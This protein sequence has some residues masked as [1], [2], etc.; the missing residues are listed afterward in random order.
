MC[1]IVGS[2]N[3]PLV[4]QI[5]DAEM[6]HRGPDERKLEQ[7][8]NISFYHL[9]LSIIDEEGGKQ[10]MHFE[11]RY[12][13]IFNG[14]I[15][16]YKSLIKKYNLVCKTN[17]DTEVV[18]QLYHKFGI[19]FLNDVDGMFAF[20]IYDKQEKRM[21]I[22]RDRA[23]KKP[24]Y[25]FQNSDKLVFCSELRCL[26][27]LVGLEYDKQNLIDYHRL[28]LFYGACTPYKNVQEL[29]G[30]QVAFIDT[31]SVSVVTKTWWNIET[32]YDKPKIVDHNSILE[33]L[34]EKLHNSIKTRLDSSD[35]EVGAFLSSGIDSSLVSSIAAQYKNKL[36]TFTVSLSGQYDEAPDARKVAEKY[37]TE[38]Y[39]LK[40]DFHDLENDIEQIL[41]NHGEPFYDS[42]S[43][44]SYYV[45]KE[46]KKHLTVILNGDGA[47]E[48]F[49]GYRRYVPFRYK[50]LFKHSNVFSNSAKLL[51][52]ILPKSNEKKSKLN[53]INRI[54]FLASAKDYPLYLRAT[55]D[56]IEGFENKL[57]GEVELDAFKEDFN[58]ISS[59]KEYSGLDKML[60]LDFKTFLHSTL[61]V[62][63][64]IATMAHS[65]EG[66][67]PFLSKELLEFAPVMPD[68]YKINGTTTKVALRKLAEKYLPKQ[69]VGLPK[70]GFEI[71]LKS[72]MNNQLNDII[73]DYLLASN[74]IS[75]EFVDKN[76]LLA[77]LENRINVGEEKR[78]KI[79]WHFFCFEVWY[80]KVYLN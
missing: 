18:L 25:I 71:P 46:A 26:H 14:E 72:W 33:Q 65:L 80:K 19:D 17:S 60:C 16:N 77:L 76:F 57:L 38:H 66:R 42:S 48:L 29:K 45:S 32:Q 58:R 30:G 50:D 8:G 12:V 5:V 35:L 61:L 62:K 49:A 28:G 1:G 63:M 3:F 36:K 23:G 47:D 24:V 7:F 59:N 69:I 44:P 73:H 43:I 11:N 78:A 15:Y 70:M 21:C 51:K 53:Y 6:G 4:T 56:K 41:V 10:P 79:L 2:I 52:S 74:S 20:A 55:N 9:R 40:I 67:S 39:E 27:R 54:A 37:D 68:S 22:A 31:H 75:K 13:L 64:D 34:E